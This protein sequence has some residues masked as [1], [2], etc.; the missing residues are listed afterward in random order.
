MKPTPI[1]LRLVI[2]YGTRKKVITIS[3]WGK[4]KNSVHYVNYPPAL[5]NIID[6][7]QRMANR[8]DQS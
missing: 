8:I 7:I 2:A 4:D 5:D 3:I 6:A 1:P